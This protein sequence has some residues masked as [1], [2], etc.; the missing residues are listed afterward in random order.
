MEEGAYLYPSLA[1]A[2]VGCWKIKE[3]DNYSTAEY[4]LQFKKKKMPLKVEIYIYIY[5]YLNFR[6]IEGQY[7]TVGGIEWKNGWPQLLLSGD[8][9]RGEVT[10]HSA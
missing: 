2:I 9:G 10:H 1:K 8:E 7:W 5:I 3:G 4:R 6:L